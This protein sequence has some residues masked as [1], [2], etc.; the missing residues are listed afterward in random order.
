MHAY[1]HTYIHTYIVVLLPRGFVGGPFIVTQ[2]RVRSANQGQ[3][4]R[5]LHVEHPTELRAD[6]VD[7]DAP[8]VKLLTGAGRR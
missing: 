2:V 6:R 1:I 7:D 3:Q 4:Q 5:Q 8:P